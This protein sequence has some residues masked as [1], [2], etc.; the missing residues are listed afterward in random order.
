MTLGAMLCRVSHDRLVL[1]EGSDEERFRR[2]G[3]LGDPVLSNTKGM[4][5]GKGQLKQINSEKFTDL[6]KARGLT[7]FSSGLLTVEFSNLVN[8][9][10]HSHQK[11]SS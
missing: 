6:L 5:G 1:G 4:Q 11:F 7:T 2:R 9:L 3:V 10:F 8:S